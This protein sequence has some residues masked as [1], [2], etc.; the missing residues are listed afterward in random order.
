MLVRLSV[1]WRRPQAL[2]VFEPPFFAAR[3]PSSALS[4][5]IAKNSSTFIHYTYRN[6]TRRHV[7][8]DATEKIGLYVALVHDTRLVASCKWYFMSHYEKHI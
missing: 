2:S 8:V 3:Q 4:L 5:D 6:I 1:A 7:A